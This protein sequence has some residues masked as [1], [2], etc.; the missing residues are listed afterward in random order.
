M[1]TSN[2]AGQPAGAGILRPKFLPITPVLSSPMTVFLR[3]R[4]MARAAHRIQAE[5]HVDRRRAQRFRSQLAAGHFNAHRIAQLDAYIG[6]IDAE[7]KIVRDHMRDLGGALID[8]AP[9]IDAITTL[10]QRLDLLGCNITDRSDIDEPNP[11]IV[12]LMAA[13]C[14]E[15]S[16][17]HRADEF[18]DRPLHA[19]VNAE[20][21]HKMFSTPEGRAATRPIFDALFAPCGLFEGVPKYFQQPDGTMLRQAPAL[22]VHDAA[23]SRV[24][25][26]KPS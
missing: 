14:L 17:E 2:A 20:I 16:A 7:L 1:N 26:R 12:L 11:G 18:N 9:E 23:G 13:Y 4:R 3:L 8:V 25:E 6:D 21:H 19:C 24:V 10:S 15:D 5:Y 22:T